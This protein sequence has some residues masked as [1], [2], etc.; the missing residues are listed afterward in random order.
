MPLQPVFCLPCKPLEQMASNVANEVP[1]DPA[2]VDEGYEAASSAGGSEDSIYT[3]TISTYIREGIEETIRKY[4][5][6][7]KYASGLPVEEP[8]QIRKGHRHSN[9]LKIAT[10]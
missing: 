7:G 8:G 9:H 2:F 10:G 3:T 4:A 1:A 5:A 6:Y